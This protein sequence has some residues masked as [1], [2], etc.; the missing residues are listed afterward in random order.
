[1]VEYTVWDRRTAEIVCRSAQP[2]VS[3]KSENSAIRESGIVPTHFAEV[4]TREVS[5]EEVRPYVGDTRKY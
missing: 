2:D 1:M 3:G 5:R 4:E